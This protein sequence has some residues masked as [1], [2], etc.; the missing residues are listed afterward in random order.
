MTGIDETSGQELH[1]ARTYEDKQIRWGARHA[2][3]LSE[4]P[5]GLVLD[6]SKFDELTSTPP[7]DAFPYSI[8]RGG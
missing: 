6:V 2:D 1:A 8:A 4:I 7:T 3:M 5:N